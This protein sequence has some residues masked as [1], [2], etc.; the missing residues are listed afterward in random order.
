VHESRPRTLA[1]AYYALSVIAIASVCL[2]FVSLAVGADLLNTSRLQFVENRG[3]YP[4]GILYR[5]DAGPATIWFTERG[6]YLQL[7][8]PADDAFLGET[9]PLLSSRFESPAGEYQTAIIPLT[10]A[11][12]NANPVITHSQIPTSFANYF[13]GDDQSQWVSDAP[14]YDEIT[15]QE[16]YPGIDLRYYGR[17]NRLEYDFQVSAGADPSQIRI[18]YASDQRLTINAEGQLVIATPLGDLTENIP[19]IYQQDSNKRL[20]ISGG[21]RLINDHTFGFEINSNYRRDLPLIIDPVLDY[22]TYVG[23]TA[24]DYGR[25]IALSSAGHAYITGFTA[26]ADFP[27]VGAYDATYN[28]GGALGFDGFITKMNIG[29]DTIYYSTYFGG[30]T[31]EDRSL[32][33]AVNPAGQAFVTGTTYSTDFPTV[34]PYQATNAGDRDVFVLKLSAAGNSIVYS[35]YIGGTALDI[36]SDIVINS[37]GEAFVTGYTQSAGYDVAGTPFDNTLGGTEDAFITRLNAGGNSLVAST[38]F[39]GGAKDEAFGLTLHAGDTVYICGQTLS[40]DLPFKSAYDST[41]GGGSS[42]GDIF[43]AK[44]KPNLDSLKFST[45]VGTVA[46]ELALDVKVDSYGNSYVCGYTFS[47]TF[48]L[49]GAADATFAGTTEGVVF[50][51]SPVGSTLTYSTFLGGMSTDAPAAIALSATNRAFV[52]GNT[53]SNNFPIVDAVQG[54]FGGAQDVFVSCL[55]TTGNAFVYS[56]YL[57]GFGSDFSYNIAVD[58]GA[59]AYVAGY[60]GSANFPVQSAVQD[61]LLG[62]YDAFVAK[63]LITPFVCFDTDGDGY[64]NPGHPENECQTDNCPTIVNVSQAD[65]DADAVGD[66]CDNCPSTVN[67]SQTDSDSDGIGDACDICTD[68]DG[69]GFGNPGFPANTCPLDNCPTITNIS[70]QDSDGDGIGDPCDNCTDTDGDGYGNAGFP[71]NTCGLDN[72][73]TTANPTQLDSDADGKGNSCDNCPNNA[74]ANQLDF[75]NDGTGDACD[76]CTDN[77]GDGFANPGYPASTCGIDNCPV[78]PNPSQTDTNSN[79]VGDACDFG[80]C[81][82]PIRG[83]VNGDAGN[84]VN[85]ADIT[86]LVRYLFDNGPAPLCIDE[87][88]VNG[89]TTTIVNIIDVNHLV[90]YLFL[91]GPAP[92]ACP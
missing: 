16:L 65:G 10:F 37:S 70:Q 2:G 28:G 44:F 14:A 23:G 30:T 36:G 50:K 31:G 20:P 63:I 86:Y 7:V 53:G 82:A 18:Q 89:S 47:S 6:L 73:P 87:A 84:S 46:D 56:T 5:A 79:G 25:G 48:P 39:G 12:A 80:C 88:N 58:T 74:N 49:V 83:N 59:S 68:T 21:Y 92:A 76:L 72:C 4:S 8:K 85:V 11:G 90:K 57:G 43:V 62:G 91:A 15:F 13:I 60:T 32:A 40:S 64:G 27:V 19:L 67:L 29:G 66:A 69:D 3:Q 51:L 54:S 1:V 22:S 81:V 17:H 75:D 42:T 33:I 71:A 38:F 24:N 55:D 77:D 26:S 61:E 35:T 34:T 41:Y 52:T 45:F 9:D 78:T